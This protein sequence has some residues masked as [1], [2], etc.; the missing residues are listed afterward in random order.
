[1]KSNDIIIVISIMNFRSVDLNLLRVF[2]ALDETR[3]VTRAAER[4]GL[5]QPAVSA[6]L[7]RLRYQM[8]DPLFVRVGN[9]MAPTPRAEAAAP[10]ISDALSRLEDALTATGPFRPET[11]QATFSLRGADFFSTR[12]MPP[13]AAALAREAPGVSMRFLDSGRGDLVELLESSE[14]DLALEQPTEVP[15]WVSRALLFPS[16][17]KIIAARDNPAIRSA[18]LQEGDVLP[19]DLFCDLPH[20]LRS[21]D[22]SAT[23]MT[24]TA[25]AQAGRKRRVAL[26][27]PHFDA[28]LHAVA[29]STM[30][31]SIPIQFTLEPS[32]PETLIVFEPPI[33]IPTPK[34]Q[35][36]WHSR[37]D[38]TPS[39]IWF[40]SRLLDEVARLWGHD[41]SFD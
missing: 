21:V 37:F 33:E 26:V 5:S 18:G 13:L 11:S 1:M 4:L 31:S 27:V 14:I 10:A 35:L 29:R 7:S 8:G 17:F 24:D 40:R 16:P 3:N 25:L 19:L 41:D 12:L 9:G 38:K 28:V 15:G 34:M 23:G 39:H 6:A 20:A 22:G 32:W 30:I 36:Y 2:A